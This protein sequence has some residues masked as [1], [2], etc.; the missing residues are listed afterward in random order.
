M[1]GK[2]G[3]KKGFTVAD[4]KS[5][6]HKTEEAAT[7]LEDTAKENGEPT[8]VTSE[9]K[10][11][12]KDE[13]LQL[14]SDD[15]T[16]EGDSAVSQGDVTKVEPVVSMG[17]K[18]ELPEGHDALGVSLPAAS[19]PGSEA[20]ASQPLTPTTKEDAGKASAIAPA[21]QYRT[22]FYVKLGPRTIS[23]A[24]IDEKATSL[25]QPSVESPCAPRITLSRLLGKEI[26]TLRIAVIVFIANKV[27]NEFSP[28]RII[29]ALRYGK[30]P[31]GHQ[32]SSNRGP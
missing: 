27:V 5:E 18:A 15:Q 26:K 13:S 28:S 21:N 29:I 9:V 10:V 3:K 25:P 24:T 12:K 30:R 20:Q 8:A 32:G 22:D 16:G 6:D 1:G 14:P 17:A 7:E 2:L 23:G 19:K 11:V 31:D 4:D